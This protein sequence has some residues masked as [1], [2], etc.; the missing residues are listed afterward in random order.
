MWSRGDA[1]PGVSPHLGRVGL[2]YNPVNE[3]L[4]ILIDIEYNQNSFTEVMKIIQGIKKSQVI[5]Y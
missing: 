1:I 5:I 2:G 3:A 4:G